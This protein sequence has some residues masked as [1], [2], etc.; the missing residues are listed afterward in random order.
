[1][2]LDISKLAVV[3]ETATDRLIAAAREAVRELD[4]VGAAHRACALHRAW[5]GLVAALAGIDGEADDT[6]ATRILR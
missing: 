1:M 6:Q 2:T 4:R 5:A 3:G